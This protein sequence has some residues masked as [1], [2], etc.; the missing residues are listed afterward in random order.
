MSRA[1]LRA[2]GHR[3][4]S[5]RNMH[6]SSPAQH[7]VGLL[8]RVAA[9]LALKMHSF[10]RSLTCIVLDKTSL[11]LEA[12][13]W[14]VLLL[15]ELSSILYLWGKELDLWVDQGTL[16]SLCAKESNVLPIWKLYLQSKF[17]LSRL[18]WQLL[19]LFC[20][21]LHS[22]VLDPAILKKYISVGASNDRGRVRFIF[23]RSPLVASIFH[24]VMCSN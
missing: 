16:Q 23:T 9:L 19:Q 13:S 6:A 7:G 5:K 2:C 15:K 20:L 8:V 11:A 4:P 3:G 18:L 22:V 1:L 24:C 21:V 14:L 17:N 10:Q 12:D